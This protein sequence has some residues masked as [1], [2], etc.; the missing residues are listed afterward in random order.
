[1]ND[2]CTSRDVPMGRPVLVYEPEGGRRPSMYG[3]PW[4]E[5]FMP[6]WGSAVELLKSKLTELLGRD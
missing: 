4:G 6:P 2:E 3:C 5:E 1:M